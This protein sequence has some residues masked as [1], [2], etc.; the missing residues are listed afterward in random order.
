MMC[1][2]IRRMLHEEQERALVI[3][4]Y[5][6]GEHTIL[7]YAH[8]THI[9]FTAANGWGGGGISLH[10]FDGL[11][12][13]MGKHKEDYGGSIAVVGDDDGGD[14]VIELLRQFLSSGFA[15]I[16]MMASIN[17]SCELWY[18]QRNA[19]MNVACVCDVI[20]ASADQTSEY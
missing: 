3:A 15:G 4:L 11:E 16:L 14:D 8:S 9:S 13:F 19:D 6:W 2:V 1:A 17:I 7:G 10:N 5:S 20:V 12:L 18:L